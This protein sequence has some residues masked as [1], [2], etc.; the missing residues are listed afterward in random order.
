MRLCTAIC[1][2]AHKH[3]YYCLTQTAPD[4]ALGCAL[5]CV[6]ASNEFALLHC[7]PC[8]VS[9]AFTPA[10]RHINVRS[11]QAS[12]AAAQHWGVLVRVASRRRVG[13]SGQ[14]AKRSELQHR[15]MLVR[16]V[17]RQA[18]LQPSTG[19]GARQCAWSGRLQTR[20]HEEAPRD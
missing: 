11:Q 12:M 10:A 6:Q 20:L 5:A 13:A 16:V 2:L 19:A 4:L 17:S 8:L 18:R 14:Q 15:G 9:A 7:R 3:G 1:A